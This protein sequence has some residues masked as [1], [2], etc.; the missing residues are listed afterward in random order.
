MNLKAKTLRGLGE[1]YDARLLSFFVTLSSK[2]REAH[3]WL[4]PP[5]DVLKEELSPT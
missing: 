1:S 4:R 3:G 2:E 5:P